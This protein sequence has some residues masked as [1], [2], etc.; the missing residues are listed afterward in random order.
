MGEIVVH[1]FLKHTPVFL[2]FSLSFSLSLARKQKKFLSRTARLSR[3]ACL[4]SVLYVHHLKLL[5][6]P[7][8]ESYPTAAT[9][10]KIVPKL[11]LDAGG[12]L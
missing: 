4:I 5:F 3:L 1:A 9:R 2:S 11:V 10:E 7:I 8:R 6:F 12:V